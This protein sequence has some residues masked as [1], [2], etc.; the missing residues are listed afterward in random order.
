MF[1]SFAVLAVFLAAVGLYGVLSFTVTQ[2]TSEFGVRAA[3]GARRGRIVRQVMGGGLAIVG[4]GLALGGLASWFASSAIQS[5]LFNTDAR[6]VAPYAV[7]VLVLGLV[8]V[9][10]SAIPAWRASSVDPA[11]ALRAE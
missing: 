8:A 7:A 11:I 9:I 10:A 2:R 5:L 6:A 3:L 4:A 1:G